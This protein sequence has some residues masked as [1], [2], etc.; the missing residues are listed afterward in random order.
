MISGEG[1]GDDVDYDDDDDEYDNAE[2]Y[3]AAD[4]A[5]DDD[6]DDGDVDFDAVIILI[7]GKSR[8]FRSSGPCGGAR[9]MNCRRHEMV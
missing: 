8:R 6:E 7:F 5:D 3:D 4:D 2:K 1:G 9:G